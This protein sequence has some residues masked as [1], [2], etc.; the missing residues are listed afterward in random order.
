MSL[1]KILSAIVLVLVVS[2]CAQTG[3][4]EQMVNAP[5]ELEFAAPLH[6]DHPLVGQFWSPVS[7]EFVSWQEVDRYLPAGG[8]LMVGEQHD[9][10][11]HHL[12]ERFFIEYLGRQG[13]LGSVALEIP[14]EDLQRAAT[15]YHVTAIAVDLGESARAK[16]RRSEREVAHFSQAHSDYLAK[17]IVDSH[18]GMFGADRAQPFVDVQIARDQHMAIQ[19]ME[20]TVPSAV[21][22]FIGGS[23]HVRNDYGIPIWLADELNVRT[24]VL[25]QVNENTDPRSYLA[26]RL[27]SQAPAQL[28]F[29]VPAIEPVDYCAQFRQ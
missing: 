17:L 8:W 10:P 6:R 14:R 1:V 5:G 15:R 3:D 28:L 21:S 13:R 11:D 22:V 26:D 25:V 23:G 24:L 9:H 16:I 20:N 29:F 4:P 19:L 7:E 27:D 2:S 12:L 18:C